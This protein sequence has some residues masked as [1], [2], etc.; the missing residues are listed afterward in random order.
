MLTVTE[1]NFKTVSRKKA[2]IL[3]V[4]RESH[5]PIKTLIERVGWKIS[6]LPIG[7]ITDHKSTLQE[8]PIRPE[9]PVFENLKR[10]IC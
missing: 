4:Y 5:H 1:R 6:W 8:N 7:L 2:I 3:T 10:K 9:V